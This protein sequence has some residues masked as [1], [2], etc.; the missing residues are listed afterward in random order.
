VAKAKAKP[1]AATKKAAPKKAKAAPKKAKSA[2]KT[3]RKKKADEDDEDDDI[4][5]EEAAAEAEA[6]PADEDEDDDEDEASEEVADARVAP[7]SPT[8][9]P[10]PSPSPSPK[11]SRSPTPAPSP[12]PS[13]TSS[14]TTISDPGDAVAML[15]KSTKPW[16][17]G[18]RHH[19][20][21]C[22]AALPPLLDKLKPDVVAI[23]LPA[24]ISNWLEWLG[25][26]KTKAP[27][28]LAVVSSDGKDLGFYPFADF[29][30]EMAAARWA[31]AN[32]K[33][34][35]AIDLPASARGE[36]EDHDGAPLGITEQ[37]VA[38]HQSHD[39]ES[40][41]DQLVESRAVG[42]DP[43]A[44]RRAAL[45]Y[46]WALRADHAHGGGVSPRDRRRE[47]HMRQSI[48][49]ASKNGKKKVAAVIGSFHA[50]ALLD[51]PQ[52]WSEPAIRGR[53]I[54]PASAIRC[55]STGDG[56]RCKAR[57]SARRSRRWP[58]TSWSR[59]CATS[60]KP[61]IRPACPTRTRR[62]RWRR[63][64]PGCAGC[65]RRVITKSSSRRNRR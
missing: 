8:P 37:L 45:L 41:W 24:D 31:I 23:E 60:G 59:S 11:P 21:A 19:S 52:L 13:V 5:E 7:P 54:R 47:A 38:R 18:V 32:K 2:P 63:R 3:S 51:P 28:A 35:I 53:D 6:E 42:A 34:L 44:L 25:A 29:S 50:A 16:L 65:R 27:V 40:L 33:E 64:S 39:S 20:P 58:P 57:T 30:P 15:A 1:K 62:G 10:S 61:D 56:A 48:A 36:E 14:S 49:A 9:K 46:G 22:A 12:S 43:E 17:F 4:V 26:E 55:G